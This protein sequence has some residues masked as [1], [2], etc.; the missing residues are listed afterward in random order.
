MITKFKTY[1]NENKSISF[2]P[3]DLIPYFE[4]KVDLFLVPFIGDDINKFLSDLLMN[5][6]VEF[7]CKSCMSDEDDVIRTKHFDRQHKGV[8]KGVSS[9]LSWGKENVSLTLTLNRIRYTHNVN[10]KKPII[11][12]G[13]ISKDLLEIIEGINILSNTKKYNL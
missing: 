5:R 2:I 8:V 13:D 9:G 4:D 6:M 12:Y 7:D 1:E 10:T 11:V 3:N